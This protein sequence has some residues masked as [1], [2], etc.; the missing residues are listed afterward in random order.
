MG[1]CDWEDVCRAVRLAVV[2]IGPDV[3]PLVVDIKN[4]MQMIDRDS[5]S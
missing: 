5:R 2:R 4:V 1:S 3:N